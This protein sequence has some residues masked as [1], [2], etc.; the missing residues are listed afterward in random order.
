MS[1]AP[2]EGTILSRVEQRGIEPVP[3]D[4]RNGS[5]GQLFWVWFAANISILGIPLGAT[6]IAQG[7]NLWQA[8]LATTIGAFGSFALVGIISIAG[9]RGGAPTLTLSRA[10]FGVRGNA[11]PTLVALL[12]RLGWETVN[13][14]TGAFA[15][16]SLIAIIFGTSADAKRSPFLTFACI[17]VFVALTMVVSAAGHAFI[18]TVQKWAT[19]IFGA[20]TLLVAIYLATTVDWS[21]FIGNAPGS[22]G[23]FLI[24]VGT[25]AAG[26]GIGWVNSG[27][28]MARYQKTSVNSGSLVLTAA[29]GAGIPLVV[30]IGLGSVLT[31]GNSTIA[32]AADPV[33]AVR[34]ALPAWV[35]IPYLIAAFAGL[36]MSNNLSVYSAGLTTITLGI[37]IPRVYAVVVD[38]VVTT[39]GALYFTLGSDGFYGPFVTFIS[40]LAVPLSTWAGIFLSDMIFRNRYDSN[41]L[42]N[43]QAD[44]PYWYWHG[45]N[46]P[47][48][49]SWLVGIVVGFLFVTARVSKDEVWFSGPLAGS[50]LGRN[51]LAWLVSLL[52][53]GIL[54]AILHL[55]SKD[56]LAVRG[57]SHD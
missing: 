5:P 57:K 41:G 36:L 44:S 20:L 54:Y 38:V 4:Q 21:S 22:A 52:L 30:V 9:R 12:S 24:G 13:T 47:A 1:T 17:A 28:D 2:K 50:F 34:S 43:L 10:I 45:V 33:A 27:A 42:L 51:G 29:A 39:C 46:L 26:T 53:G 40:L 8:V 35:S 55:L 16:L 37:R 25:I 3:E 56:S 32:S 18:L 11:G 23:T 31:A 15:L 48:I 7:L 49:I 14:M 19:W 6:L